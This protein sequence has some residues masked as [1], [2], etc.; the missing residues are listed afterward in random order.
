MVSLKIPPTRGTSVSGVFLPTITRSPRFALSRLAAC[1][2]EIS[3]RG[4]S[5]GRNLRFIL[6]QL[7][8][9]KAFSHLPLPLHSQAYGH[10]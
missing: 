1:L 2:D 10:A 4:L 7:W 9:R 8:L 3:T 5:L 6:A